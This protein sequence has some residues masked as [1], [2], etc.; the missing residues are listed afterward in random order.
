MLVRDEKTR[1]REDVG[2]GQWA[3]KEERKRHRGMGTERRQRPDTKIGQTSKIEYQKI[4]YQ[5]ATIELWSL[6]ASR[7]W[8]SRYTLRL[9]TAHRNTA[10]ITILGAGISRKGKYA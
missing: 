10:A 1:N 3:L 5:S 8:T 7:S 4:E 9:K 6:E 2:K